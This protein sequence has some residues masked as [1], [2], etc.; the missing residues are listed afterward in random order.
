MTSESRRPFYVRYRRR[1]LFG[2]WFAGVGLT[3]VAYNATKPRPA[4]LG[5]DDASGGTDVPT[6]QVGALPVT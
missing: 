2:S 3:V 5:N 4:R 1:L 6:I